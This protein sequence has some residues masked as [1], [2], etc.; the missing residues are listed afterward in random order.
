MLL[1][2]AAVQ[3]FFHFTSSLLRRTLGEVWRD[4]VGWL[5]GVGGVVGGHSDSNE[6]EG[7]PFQIIL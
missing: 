7:C 1:R 5:G 6:T 3:Y 4:W 2:A